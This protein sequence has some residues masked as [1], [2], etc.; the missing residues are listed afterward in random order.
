MKKLPKTPPAAP[1]LMAALDCRDVIRVLTRLQ[2]QTN[3]KLA[4]WVDHVLDLHQPGSWQPLYAIKTPAVGGVYLV[5]RQGLERMS[6]ALYVYNRD[7]KGYDHYDGPV[8]DE[9]ELNT[10]L[11]EVW[12]PT[13]ADHSELI[14]SRK[15]HGN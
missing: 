5:R 3:A 1:A 11:C 13:P 10:R 14:Q 6:H 15:A 9:A 2:A 4:Y 7:T 8:F 12:I